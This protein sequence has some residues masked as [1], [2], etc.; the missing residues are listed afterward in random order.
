MHEAGC[1]KSPVHSPPHGNGCLWSGPQLRQSR[2]VKKG[3]VNKTRGSLTAPIRDWVLSR[4]V[5]AQPP[6]GDR[7]DK[8]RRRQ[9][10]AVVQGLRTRC[11][12]PAASTADLAP[13]G[14]RAG[15]GLQQLGLP[16]P[17]RKATWGARSKQ[18]WAGWGWGNGRGGRGE[19]WRSPESALVHCEAPGASDPNKQLPLPPSNVLLRAHPRTQLRDQHGLLPLNHSPRSCTLL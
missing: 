12:S 2:V 19:G 15:E 14:R 5:C 6:G 10:G 13:G 9:P 4:A 8:R 3:C 1:W 16:L 17:L 18:C 11:C 7:G